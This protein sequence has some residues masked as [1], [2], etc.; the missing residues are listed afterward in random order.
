MIPEPVL[1]ELLGHDRAS[2]AMSVYSN[3]Y[4]VKV[5]YDE[6]QRLDYGIDFKELKW[7]A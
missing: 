2:L 7:R 1:T 5:L 4:D 3:R 6:M